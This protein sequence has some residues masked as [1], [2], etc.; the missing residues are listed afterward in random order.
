[1]E[2]MDFQMTYLYMKKTK[3]QYNGRLLN[4][5]ET[6]SMNNLSF[7]PKKMQFKSNHSM[8]WAQT[9]EGIKPDLEKIKVAVEMKLPVH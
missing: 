8:F 6:A 1:M 9:S 7:N 3:I 4:L 5:L 2:F